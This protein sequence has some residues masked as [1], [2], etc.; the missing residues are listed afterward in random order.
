[1]AGDGGR[2]TSR[3][4]LP[5]CT[6]SSGEADVD[7]NTSEAR[8]DSMMIIRIIIIRV[9]ENIKFPGRS[10][11]RRISVFLPSPPQKSKVSCKVQIAQQNERKIGIDFFDFF[12]FAK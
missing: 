11:R 2:N 1:M 8:G 4:Y 7:H 10:S 5:S 3:S 9:I 6:S 12:F